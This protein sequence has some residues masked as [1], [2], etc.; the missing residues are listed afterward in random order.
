LFLV[1]EK[2]HPPEVKVNTSNPNLSLMD[3]ISGFPPSDALN[4]V[5]REAANS[6]ADTFFIRLGENGFNTVQSYTNW[7][8]SLVP[9][10]RHG[11]LI[12]AVLVRLLE[13]NERSGNEKNFTELLM[14]NFLHNLPKMAFLFLPFVALW[15]KLLFVRSGI[16]Y[17]HHLIVIIQSYNLTFL[18]SSIAIGLSF[19]P[20]LAGI[21]SYLIPVL[22]VHF[23]LTLKMFYQQS[24]KKTILK[25]L[26]FGWGLAIMFAFGS[27]M[28]I[29]YS[30]FSI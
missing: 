14:D 28:N 27:V 20:G 23:F 11:K 15:L 3:S 10:K 4:T 16:P 12:R 9:E 1:A 7:Q 22:A 24:W 5:I 21:S 18:L 25:S 2:S 29:L 6:E 19:I 17:M 13:I 8:D 30:I 26:I